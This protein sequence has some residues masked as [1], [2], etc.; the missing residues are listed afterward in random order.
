MCFVNY[1]PDDYPS[2]SKYVAVKLSK[3]KC[4]NGFDL[5]LMINS[6]C[7]GRNKI[8]IVNIYAKQSN[9]TLKDVNTHKVACFG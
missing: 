6:L 9:T 3:I 7:Y 8:L 5:S 2:G 4:G 1:Y